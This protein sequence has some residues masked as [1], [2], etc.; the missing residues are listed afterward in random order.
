MLQTAWE[1]SRHKEML[2]RHI[3]NLLLHRD[4]AQTQGQQR[5][6]V[7]NRLPKTHPTVS[8]DFLMWKLKNYG[9]LELLTGK[10]Q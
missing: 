3:E 10:R 1:L 9:Y 8:C 7:S 5:T 6:V 4:S 2:P